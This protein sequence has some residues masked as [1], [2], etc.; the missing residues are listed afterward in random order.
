MCYPEKKNN[1]KPY[2]EGNPKVKKGRTNGKRQN[3]PFI[4]TKK[5]TWV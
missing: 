4:N 1:Q 3:T 5:E 2:H